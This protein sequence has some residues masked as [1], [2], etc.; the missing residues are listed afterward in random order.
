[1]DSKLKAFLGHTVDSFFK[2]LR[3]PLNQVHM[4]MLM[5]LKTCPLYE[6]NAPWPL[7]A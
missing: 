1:M 5:F 6:L 7:S 4:Y 2:E 3:I